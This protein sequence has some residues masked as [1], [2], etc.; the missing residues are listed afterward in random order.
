M[1][2][3]NKASGGPLS[4]REI[5]TEYLPRTGQQYTASDGS[6]YVFWEPQ[7]KWVYLANQGY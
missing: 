2:H 1:P 6:R 3:V 5:T 7:R 4:G